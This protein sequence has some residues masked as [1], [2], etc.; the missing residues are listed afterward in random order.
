MRAHCSL[1][2][3]EAPL[4]P[5]TKIIRYDAIESSFSIID[6]RLVESVE[7]LDGTTRGVCKGVYEKKTSL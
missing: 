1:K 7:M 3:R 5:E 4:I 2:S 6:S